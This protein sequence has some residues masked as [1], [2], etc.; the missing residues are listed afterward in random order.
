MEI[1]NKTIVVTGAGSGI[2]RELT[3]QLLKK[4]ARIAA[5]DLN[6]KTLEETIQLAG[7][8]YKDRV[9]KH[10]LCITEK[11]KVELLPEE[12][13]KAHGSIDGIINNA[14]IIQPFIKIND[15]SYETINRVIDVDLFGPLYMTKTFLPHL[16]KRPEAH[17][18][19]ISSMGGFLPVPGQ[20]IYG[21]AKS[22]VKLMSEGLAAELIDTNVHV[23]VVFPGGVE[24]NIM[25]NSGIDPDK[26]KQMDA[27]K[28]KS[29]ALSPQKAAETIIKGME[30]NKV[31]VYVGKDSKMMN[32]FYRIGPNSATK[33]IAKQMKFLLD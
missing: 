32:L 9:S 7:E 12:V 27:M 23:T 5:V 30:K 25:T 2:G 1:S 8:N 31:R 17:I 21:A 11:A 26:I 14:G 18:V 24:T 4:G 20:S 28:E 15:L 10:V 33:I 13:I 29:K 3:F 6:E 16:L 19:N 22:G